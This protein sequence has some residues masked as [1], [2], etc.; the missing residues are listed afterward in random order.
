M[1][2]PPTA[3]A[4]AQRAR[5]VLRCA[6]GKTNTDVAAGL[7]L[8]KPTVGKWR[9][10]FLERPW[11]VCW[12]SHDLERRAESLMLRWRESSGGGNTLE[13]ALNGPALWAESEHH[14]PHMAC[15]RAA[16]SADPLFVEKVRDIVGLYLDPPDR[17][18]VMCVD[19]KTQ[20][21]AWTARGRCC[22]C[23]QARRR[24]APMITFGMALPP[25]LPP[26]ASPLGR[27]P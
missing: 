15:L 27:I 10:R 7:N 16:A 25:C 19:E 18:L 8:S 2:S 24:G 3:Q 11:T 13:H 22:P 4:L 21:Q 1:G 6:E 17:A 5:I 23:A 14:Q 12:T 26:Q 9:S 20:I